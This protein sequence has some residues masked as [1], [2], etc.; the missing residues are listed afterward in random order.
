[1]IATKEI[2]VLTAATMLAAGISIAP[3]LGAESQ[4]AIKEILFL[5]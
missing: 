5:F 1:M 4:I 3:L 2:A